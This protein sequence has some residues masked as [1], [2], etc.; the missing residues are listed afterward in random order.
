MHLH[1]SPSHK[2]IYTPSFTYLHLIEF[3]SKMNSYIKSFLCITICLAG[4]LIPFSSHGQSDYFRDSIKS[5]NDLIRIGKRGNAYSSKRSQA[6][7]NQ[8]TKIVLKENIDTILILNNNCGYPKD[9][10]LNIQMDYREYL[11]YSM[12]GK[13]YL[14]YFSYVN[15]HDYD[16][17]KDSLNNVWYLYCY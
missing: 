14:D 10:I 1:L 9:S 3:Y 8:L 7:Y 5:L 12:K 4:L 17:F 13:V 11:I 16:T 2:I 6:Q 15:M